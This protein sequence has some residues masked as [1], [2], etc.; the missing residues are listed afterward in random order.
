MSTG[1]KNGVTLSGVQTETSSIDDTAKCRWLFVSSAE[2]SR[3][4][5][6]KSAGVSVQSKYNVE[7]KC[8]L[9]LPSPPPSA[10]APSNAM[11]FDAP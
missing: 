9:E 3:Q 1:R 5:N 6:T 7:K 8:Q 10:P 11:G 2:T 4:I